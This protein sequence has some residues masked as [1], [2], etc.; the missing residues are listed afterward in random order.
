MAIKER[1]L[2]PPSKYPIETD[3]RYLLIQLRTEQ[4]PNPN[5]KVGRLQISLSTRLFLTPTSSPHSGNLTPH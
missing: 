2:I 4:K 1:D 3:S 5:T